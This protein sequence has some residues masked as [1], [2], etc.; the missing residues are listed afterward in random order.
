MEVRVLR[1]GFAIFFFWF[2]FLLLLPLV[3][4]QV[5]RGDR[6][7]ILCDSDLWLTVFVRGEKLET[8]C[9]SVGFAKEE[10]TG[11]S[12]WCW[13]GSECLLLI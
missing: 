5:R 9:L 1:C 12:N 4:G 8:F 13:F 6:L 3:E 11:L 2:L 7:A 10:V